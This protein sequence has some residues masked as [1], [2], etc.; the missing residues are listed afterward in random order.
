MAA[1]EIITWGT[2]E[3][4]LLVHGSALDGP[5]TWAPQRPLSERWALHVVQR[6][7]FG[8]SPDTDGED[9]EHD[10]DDLC[11]L[12]AEPAH[13]V[14]HAYGAIGALIAAE[15]R[16]RAVRTLTLIEP[17]CVTAAMDEP[18]IAQAIGAIADWWLHA[19]A[20]PAEFLAG[21]SALLGVRVPELNDGPAGL[22]GAARRLRNTR[23][24]WM[25]EPAWDRVADARIPTL[26][27]SGG[28]S[29]ALDAV[30][31][32]VARNTGGRSKLIRG[33]G[34]AVQRA[35]DA[36]NPMLESHMSSVRRRVPFDHGG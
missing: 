23:P 12:L 4:V 27:V 28:S 18:D 26:V 10:A 19:P 8:S 30:A 36:F 2:G 31:A 32:A 25:A 29:P 21:Y 16:P 24:P 35:A 14:A 7:G 34:H 11:E 22:P 5:A 15:R 17:T 33:A 1:L 13:L 6:R 9:F 3:R 20:D